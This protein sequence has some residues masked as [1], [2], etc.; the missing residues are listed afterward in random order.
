M[1]WRDSIIKSIRI[2]A[3]AING[4]QTAISSWRHDRKR[5]MW[6][7]SRKNGTYFPRGK[8][9]GSVMEN[10]LRWSATQT[11]NG[12]YGEEFHCI[13]HQQPITAEPFAR[14][15]S[16]PP[17]LSPLSSSLSLLRVCLPNIGS[18]Q[19]SISTEENLRLNKRKTFQ[20]EHV[21]DSGDLR[22][23]ARI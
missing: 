11:W 14:Q 16:S 19:L 7:F 1:G 2:E 8:Q 9:R 5:E 12:S 4:W 10:A 6:P 3:S 13:N 18:T 17:T 21:F 15:T 22:R 20:R 23:T